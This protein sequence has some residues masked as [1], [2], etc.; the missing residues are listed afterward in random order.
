MVSVTL[1]VSDKG[2]DPCKMRN[3]RGEPSLTVV[4]VYF[5][6]ESPGHNTEK[7]NAK[8]AW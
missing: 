3:K 4:S 8:K 6:R 1:D 5:L 7:G 2:R